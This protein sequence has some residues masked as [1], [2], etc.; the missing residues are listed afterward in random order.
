MLD[1]LQ[2]EIVNFTNFLSP[3]LSIT[4]SARLGIERRDIIYMDL[5]GKSLKTLSSPVYNKYAVEH[6]FQPVP[7]RRITFL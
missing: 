1:Y 5:N 7:I 3:Y 4:F 2:E 6:A